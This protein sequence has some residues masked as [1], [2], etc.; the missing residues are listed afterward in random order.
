VLY[1]EAGLKTD[2]WRHMA[3]PQTSHNIDCVL[4]SLSAIYGPCSI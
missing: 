4:G 1:V 2:G 3:Y